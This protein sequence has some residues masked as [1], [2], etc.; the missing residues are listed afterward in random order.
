[1]KVEPQN[2]ALPA[3]RGTSV[4]PLTAAVTRATPAVTAGT[5]TGTLVLAAACWIIAV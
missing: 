4:P 2:A 3:V 1:M 5:L